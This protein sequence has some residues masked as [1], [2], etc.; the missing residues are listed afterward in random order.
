MTDDNQNVSATE[1]QSSLSVPKFA[2]NWWKELVF[3]FPVAL[4]MI[5]A[6]HKQVDMVPAISIG[7]ALGVLAVYLAHI[8]RKLMFTELSV[9]KLYKTSLGNPIGAGITF[10]A[11]IYFVVEVAKLLATQ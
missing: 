4:L 8:V 3:F 6:L 5:L 9:T 11:L 2:I 10:F 1:E 7:L